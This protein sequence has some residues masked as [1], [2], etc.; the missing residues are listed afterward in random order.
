LVPAE[1]PTDPPTE[2]PGPGADSDD[3]AQIRSQLAAARREGRLLHLRVTW[4]PFSLG[5]LLLVSG[6]SIIIFTPALSFG[7]Y[8]GLICANVSVPILLLACPPGISYV[9]GIGALLGFVAAS[10]LA[11]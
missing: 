9:V 8:M 1:P 6:G 7:W 2:P 4:L 3:A 10:I 11:I 5:I